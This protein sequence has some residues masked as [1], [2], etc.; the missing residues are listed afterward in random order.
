MK[1]WTPQDGLECPI[2][3][4]QKVTRIKNNQD[5]KTLKKRIIFLE[6]D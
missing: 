3:S 1:Q 5:V 4:Q 2:I 6:I